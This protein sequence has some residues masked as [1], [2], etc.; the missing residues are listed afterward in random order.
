MLTESWLGESVPDSAIH[1]GCNLAIHRRDRPTPG[2]VLL[3]YMYVHKSIPTQPG[4][5]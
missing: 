2:G 4:R 3:A 5:S 1:M